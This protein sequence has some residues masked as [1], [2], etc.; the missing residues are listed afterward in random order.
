MAES[1]F[2][3]QSRPLLAFLLALACWAV[4]E[5]APASASSVQPRAAS[6]RALLVPGAFRLPASNGY[7]LYVL[8]AQPREGRPGKV[9]IFVTAKGREVIYSAPATV[10]ETSIQADLGELGQ[11]SVAFQRTGKPT[12][13]SCGKTTVSLDSGDYEGTIDFRGE[14][15]YTS[16]EATMAPGLFTGFCSGGFLAGGPG[17]Y[18]GGAELYVRNPALGPELSV[19]KSRPTAAAQISASTSEYRNEILIERFASLRIPTADFTYDRRLRTATLRPPAP[20]SGSA[21]FDLDKKAGRRWSGDLSVDLP[22]SSGVP[23]TGPTLR[24]SLV[25][26]E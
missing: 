9:L 6:K 20:F 3:K 5:A 24:A 22:G 16:V 7:T 18:H 1:R 15:G 12:D 10:T 4:L 14:E 26:S 17:R 25:P 11:I 21:R 23:L 8:A 13:V 2:A 19:R